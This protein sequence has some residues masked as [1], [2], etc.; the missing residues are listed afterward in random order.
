[1]ITKSPA[2]TRSA[3]LAM[4]FQGRSIVPALSSVACVLRCA[5][6]NVV[7]RTG[8]MKKQSDNPIENLPLRNI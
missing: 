8:A 7:P 6:K 4:L 2:C 1:M 5:T 3:A